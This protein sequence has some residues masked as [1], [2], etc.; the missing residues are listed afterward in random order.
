MD[1]WFG[2]EKRKIHFDINTAQLD[3]DVGTDIAHLFFYR[4][5]FESFFIYLGEVLK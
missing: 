5:R 1:G 4:L 3:G 2:E